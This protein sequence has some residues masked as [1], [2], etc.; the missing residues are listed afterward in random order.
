MRSFKTTKI[1]LH[2]NHCYEDGLV[3]P[4]PMWE[5]LADDMILCKYILVVSC[6]ALYINLIL[7]YTT[8]FL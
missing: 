7:H 1:R 3:N 2:Q 6:L 8:G 4:Y 5:K